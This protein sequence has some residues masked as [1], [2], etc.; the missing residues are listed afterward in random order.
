[1][2][3]VFVITIIWKFNWFAAVMV[4]GFILVPGTALSRVLDGRKGLR[5]HLVL[6]I[7][8]FPMNLIPKIY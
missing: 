6:M 5:L 3:N 8:V 2:N 7:L 1:M 4:K